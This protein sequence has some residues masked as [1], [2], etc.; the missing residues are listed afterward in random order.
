MPVVAAILGGIGGYG[1]Y[2]AGT[3]MSAVDFADPVY[4]PAIVGVLWAALFPVLALLARLWF[5]D[6]EGNG[7]EAMA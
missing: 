1:S 3:A 2:L 5:R 6:Q 4:G 7:H